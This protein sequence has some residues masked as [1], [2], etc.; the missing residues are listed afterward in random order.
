MEGVLAGATQ[1]GEMKKEEGNML[2]AGGGLEHGG[3]H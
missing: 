2:H 1:V 3:L